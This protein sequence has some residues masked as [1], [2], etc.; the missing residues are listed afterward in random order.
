MVFTEFIVGFVNIVESVA[1]ILF[2]LT[3]VA[4]VVLADVV[5]L[6]NWSLTN[7]FALI[8]FHL[9]VRITDQRGMTEG[10]IQLFSDYKSFV[11]MLTSMV[12]DIIRSL[13]ALIPFT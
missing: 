9:F 11:I 3:N 13:G 4:S 2:G 5:G 6:V 12:T 8:M 1:L 7:A 10:V